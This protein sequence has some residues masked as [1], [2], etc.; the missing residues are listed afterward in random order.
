[1]NI[2]PSIQTAMF[3][4][5][6]NDLKFR[7]DFVAEIKMACALGIIIGIILYHRYMRNIELKK[8]LLLTTLAASCIGM[9]TILLVTKEN[10]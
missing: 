7:A 3:Y 6:T 4:F 1:M 9:F 2:S 5:Y 8:T 10:R